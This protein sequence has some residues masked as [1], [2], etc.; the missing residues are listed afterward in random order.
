MGLG[1]VTK[2]NVND[3]RKSTLERLLKNYDPLLYIKWNPEK[4]NGIGVWEI[5]RRP[6]KKEE[7]YR[8][9]WI[10]GTPVYELDYHENDL[11][12]HVLDI[13]Y[14]TERVLTKLYEMDTY[15]VDKW[16]DKFDY[17][18]ERSQDKLEA[19]NREELAYQ[20]RH[21]RK[22]IEILRESVRDGYNPA[23]FFAGFN[24]TNK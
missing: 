21:H 2:G 9:V 4:R 1:R 10:D 12:N 23:Q 15:R 8:G 7:Y 6:T 5:R 18:Q 3:C 24:K 14:L 17:E 19:Q 13:P 16:V 20:L 22:E 11:V